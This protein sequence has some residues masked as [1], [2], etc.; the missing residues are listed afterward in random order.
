MNN[1]ERDTMIKETHVAVIGLSTTC[2][3]REKEIS[4]LFDGYNQT[5]KNTVWIKVLTGVGIAVWTVVTS[6][7]GWIITQK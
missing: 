5:Q 3:A 7:V 6:A 4:T 2:R 1:D